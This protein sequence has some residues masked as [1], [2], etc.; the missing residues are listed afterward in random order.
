[1]EIFI[2]HDLVDKGFGLPSQRPVPPQVQVGGR[3]VRSYS[4]FF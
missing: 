3:F 4:S 2:Y 1:M